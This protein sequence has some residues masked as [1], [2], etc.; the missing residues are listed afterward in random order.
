MARRDPI[1]TDAFISVYPA[2]MQAIVQRLRGVV[3]R[4]VPDA[5]EGVRP[6]WHLIGYD[7]PH[8]RRTVY[9]AYIAPETIHVHLG[10][11][12][13][14]LMADPE[15]R[16]QGAGITRQVRWLTYG[17]VHEIDEAVIEPLLDEAV[18]VARLGRAGRLALALDREPDAGP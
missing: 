9:V 5:I 7:V 14:A 8:G 11:E 4:R 17:R 12:H 10:F 6:G 13:G 1:P 15:R 3:A 18:R 2:P 16:L